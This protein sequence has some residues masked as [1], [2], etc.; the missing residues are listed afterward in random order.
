MFLF[1]LVSLPSHIFQ[2]LKMLLLILKIFF[3]IVIMSLFLVLYN[4]C[5]FWDSVKKKVTHLL[6][7]PYCCFSISFFFHSIPNVNY[8]LFGSFIFLPLF[9]NWVKSTK[10]KALTQWLTYVYI[11]IKTGLPQWLRMVE[12]FCNAGDWGPSLGQ[13]DPLEK[14]MATHSSILQYSCLGDSMD[15]GAWWATIHGVAES[16]TWLSN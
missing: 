2:I 8:V 14:G 15:R 10:L 3:H 6:N 9:P 4:S 11:L 16:W 7:L 13:E 5:F 12:P 1:Y